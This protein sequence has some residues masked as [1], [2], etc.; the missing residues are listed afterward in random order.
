MK[1]IQTI[2]IVFVGIL[3]CAHSLAA[4][5]AQCGGKRPCGNK[6]Y[7]ESETAGQCP[8][9]EQPG[10]CKPRPEI[11]PQDCKLVCGCDGKDYCN[12]CI[13]EQHGTSLAH[14]GA[15]GSAC[16][17]AADCKGML[18]HICKVCSDGKEA[19]A[20]FVCTQG[21]CKTEVCGPP[22]SKCTNATNCGH[23]QYCA[24]PTCS[25]AYN[26]GT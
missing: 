20:H 19:C 21:Q 9:A 7:C 22:P 18:P 5:P 12:A 2:A 16:K 24:A 26:T 4:P 8:S 13:A 1:L 15:C 23:D 10:T 6:Y 17:T 3:G 14:E 25:P 11:C